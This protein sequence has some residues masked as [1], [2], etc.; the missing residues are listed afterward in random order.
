M[1]GTLSGKIEN[2]KSNY[3][4]ECI[5]TQKGELHVIICICIMYMYNVY[6]YVYVYIYTYI[7]VIV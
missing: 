2:F 5:L 3:A 6:V 7:Y 4:Y 1:W